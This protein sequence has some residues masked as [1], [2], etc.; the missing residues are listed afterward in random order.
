LSQILSDKDSVTKLQNMAQA[1]LG[2]GFS[3]DDNGG[4]NAEN[5]K[6]EKPPQENFPFDINKLLKLSQIIKKGGDDDAVRLISAL[7]PYLENER[8][9][10]AQ[11]VIKMLRLWSAAPLL[12]ESGILDDRF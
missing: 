2:S 5:S 3:G 4:K 1:L 12:K 10:R 9:E 11:T 7:V 8:K 6:S